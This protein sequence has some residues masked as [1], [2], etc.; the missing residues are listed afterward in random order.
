MGGEQR[1]GSRTVPPAVAFPQGWA[2]SLGH[3]PPMGPH[4][5]WAA[6]SPEQRLPLSCVVAQRRLSPGIAHPTQLSPRLPEAQTAA[7]WWKGHGQRPNLLLDTA[8]LPTGVTVAVLPLPGALDLYNTH[9]LSHSHACTH[10]SAH[11]YS[12]TFAHDTHTPAHTPLHALQSLRDEGCRWRSTA[13][14]AACS[15]VDVPGSRGSASSSLPQRNPEPEGRP[16]SGPGSLRPSRP[17]PA[18]AIPLR[19]WSCDAQGSPASMWWS[20]GSALLTAPAEAPTGGHQPAG[21]W[22]VGHTAGPCLRMGAA[23]QNQED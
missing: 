18:R 3:L 21:R 22:G 23:C 17:H 15:E 6:W 12:H 20:G 5:A 9:A 14:G 16:L 2:A 19:S 1:S 13:L 8:S 7:V 11:T 10:T 4:W